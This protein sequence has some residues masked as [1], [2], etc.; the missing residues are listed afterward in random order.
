MADTAVCRVNTLRLSGCEGAGGDDVSIT[1]RGHRRISRFKQVTALFTDKTK[2]SR[3]L[4]TQTQ[5]SF[6]L[7]PYKYEPRRILMQTKHR[8]HAPDTKESDHNVVII[9]WRWL[10]CVQDCKKKVAQLLGYEKPQI[11]C[12][13]FCHMAFTF[14]VYWLRRGVTNDEAASLH[15]LAW[16]C[17]MYLRTAGDLSC[18]ETRSGYFFTGIWANLQVPR[19]LATEA[20]VYRNTSCRVRGNQKR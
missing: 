3:S 20:G 13:Y 9:L 10:V 17:W 14:Y 8:A 18:V 4:Q 16:H 6:N 5:N 2:P 7:P 11:P 19:L 1:T 12:S 15:L